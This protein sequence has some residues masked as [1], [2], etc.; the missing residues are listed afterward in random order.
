MTKLHEISMHDAKRALLQKEISSRELTQACLNRIEET[1]ALGAYLHVDTEG[2]LA[3]AD[4]ADQRRLAGDGL[5]P[6]DG[7]PIGL[8]DIFLTRD[9]PTTCGSKILKGFIA[10]YDGTAARKLKDAG[11]VLLGKLNMDE[12]A[13]GSSNEHS[14][15]GNALN[16]WNPNHVPGGSSG[17]SAAAVASGGCIGALGTDTGGSIRQPAA[18]TGTVGLKPTYGRVSRYGVIAFASSLDQVGPMTKDVEDCALLLQEIAGHDPKDSTSVERDVP[19]Y[20]ENLEAGVAGLKLG[21]PKEYFIDG[22]DPEIQKAV[23]AAI[24]QYESLGAQIVEVSLPHTDHGI[25]TYYLIAT[26]EASSN[27]ARFDGVRYGKRVEEQGDGLEQM[28]TKT[29]GAGFGAEVKRRIM[30]GTYALSAGYYDAYYLKAQKVRTL[31]RQDFANAFEKVDAIVTPT[32]PA[33]AFE[34]GANI[35]DPMAM[36]LSDVFTVSANLA[37]LPGL[38]LPCGFTGKG[39]P[40]G[41]QILGRPWDEAG[42]LQIARAYE[43][44]K[45]LVNAEGF[46]MSYETVIG[47]EVHSQLQTQT[48]LFCSCSTEFGSAPNE[49]T[50]EVCLGMPGA[51]PVLNKQAVELAL[52][53]AMGLECTIHERSQWARK[54]YF[55]PDLPKGYQITQFEFPYCTGGTLTFDVGGTSK[56]VRL[57]RIHMEEDAGKSIHDE[58]V[59]GH[60]SCVDFNRGGTPLCEIVT[61]PDLRSSEEA[62]SFLRHLRRIL[63]YFGVCDGNMEEGSLRCDANVSVRPVGQKEYGTRA[64]LKNINSFRFVQQAIDYEVARQIDVIESGGRVVQETRLWDTTAKVTRSMRSKEE[65]H[66]YR[67]FPD[68]DLPDLVL[69]PSYIASIK[70]GLPELPAKAASEIHGRDGSF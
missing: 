6:L 50:C 19:Q 35:K 67:Y 22:I 30:L 54:N 53:A 70:V 16:P 55:Y 52:R 2:A 8:K 60:R 20:C 48:K 46:I 5:G 15:Y 27:L 69:E 1:Q 12:F 43:R 25:A 41:L 10:P 7:V 68:P 63:R 62:A 49:N 18:L 32:C 4:A 13:M 11:T 42:V 34:V 64:E 3:Q 26:A 47:L 61:E 65:A 31:V 40:I 33:A 57:T 56:T 14:A 9:L 23:Q 66:D 59:A 24:K 28:Y 37:G 39:L 44:E 38:S 58:A 36:Y 51:L 45:R 21:I 17:G 29:R